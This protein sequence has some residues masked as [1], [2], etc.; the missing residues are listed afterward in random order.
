MVKVLVQFG[1]PIDEDSF[2]RH[3]EVTHRPLLREIPKLEAIG[4]H[5]VEGV[6]S[7]ESP[8]YRIVELQFGSEATMQDGLNS[9]AGQMM[10]RDFGAFATGGVTILLCRW[11]GEAIGPNT[12]AAI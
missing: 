5:H 8:V 11:D 4:I 1:P 10:A 3:F 12:H 2:D 6:V 7:G 9:E